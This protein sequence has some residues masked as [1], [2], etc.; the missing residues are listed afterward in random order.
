M[1]SLSIVGGHLDCFQFWGIINNNIK[2]VLDYASWYI[3]SCTSLVYIFLT[4]NKAYNCRA[5]ELGLGNVV[6][7]SGL[8][9]VV[10][11]RES[12]GDNPWNISVLIQRL[13]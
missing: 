3:C 9:K 8:P 4:V 13:Q 7:V 5:R 12:L 11:P 1:F 2:S 6:S 10:T